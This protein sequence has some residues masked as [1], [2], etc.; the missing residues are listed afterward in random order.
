MQL[1][2]F[3]SPVEGEDQGEESAPTDEA[4]ISAAGSPP[5]TPPANPSPCRVRGTKL[6]ML[7]P[8]QAA[9]GLSTRNLTGITLYSPKE[10]IVSGPGRHARS[11]EIEAATLRD[12]MASI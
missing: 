6:G 5:S 2:A 3:P 7:R 12:G 8:V 9:R 11:A 4:G 10:L 1:A